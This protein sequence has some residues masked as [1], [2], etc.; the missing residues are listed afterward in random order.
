M[1][2]GA[3]VA[4]CVC[5]V[6]RETKL[7]AVLASTGPAGSCYP[8]PAGHDSSVLLTVCNAFAYPCLL[9]ALWLAVVRIRNTAR[10]ELLFTLH[11]QL[12]HRVRVRAD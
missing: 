11:T 3:A 12:S 7:D 4:L 6:L 8:D 2:S 9:P 5:S 10:G 1:H